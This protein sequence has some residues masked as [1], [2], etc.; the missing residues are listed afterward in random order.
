VIRKYNN[1]VKKEVIARMAVYTKNA[2]VLD[3][4]AGRGQDLFKYIYNGFKTII[5]IDNN[6]DN[7]SEIINR[8][9]TYIRGQRA[10]SGDHTARLYI[11]NIDVNAPYV[12]NC[13][14]LAAR[15]AAH[16]KSVH[17]VV[18]NFAVHYFCF[19]PGQMTNF[20]SFIDVMLWEHKSRVM[21][22][23]LD[24]AKVAELL[25]ASPNGTWGDGERY[26]LQRCDGNSIKVML[27][28][29]PGHMYRESLVDI[30]QLTKHFARRQIKLESHQGFNLYMNLFQKQEPDAYASLDKLDHAYINLLAVIGFYR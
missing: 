24:G 6:E 28:F 11:D 1:F 18:C 22:T 15:F 23:C 7:L 2:V 5:M 29:A 26:L 12:D 8:K 20:V 13:G 25:D 27:P 17:L 10:Q 19:T 16:E 30:K 9:Y 3:I 14:T 4:A 21:I